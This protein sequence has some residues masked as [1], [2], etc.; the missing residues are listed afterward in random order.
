MNFRTILLRAMIGSLLISPVVAGSL[1]GQ[2]TDTACVNAARI[3]S[4]GYPTS[5]DNGAFRAIAQCGADGARAFAAGI[6]AYADETDIEVLDQFMTRV[7]EWRDAAIFD[8]AMQLAT[9]GAATPQARAFAV[10]HLIVLLQP[11][12][13]FSYAALTNAADTIRTKDL[14]I[15]RSACQAMIYAAREGLPVGTPLPADYE[16]RIRS[17]LASLASN[18]STPTPVRNAARCLLPAACSVTALVP[19]ASIAA[20]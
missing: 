20:P 14:T 8:A 10:R 3:V 6:A 2:G 18:P 7:D 12:F 19:R 9:N 13:V 17:T 1:H 15:F 4:K 11:Q 5:A 16:A